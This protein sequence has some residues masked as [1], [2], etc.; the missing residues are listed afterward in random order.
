MRVSLLI[1]FCL[2]VKVS[3]SQSAQS[4]FE[5]GNKAYNA[6]QF[7]KAQSFYEQSISLD[8]ENKFVQ[9][10]F[11]LAN[12]LF[13]QKKYN[14][15]AKQYQS[16]IEKSSDDGWKE[17]GYY[18]LANTFFAKQ[19]YPAAIKTYQQA[20]HLN[21]KDEDARYN[22]ALTIQLS[23]GSSNRISSTSTQKNKMNVPQSRPLTEEEKRQLL[24]H[25]SD[26]ENKTIQELDQN[27]SV[28]RK[29]SVKDW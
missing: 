1:C 9:A 25:L 17:Q 28:G 8:R 15:A 27:K 7:A 14:E 12:A 18:N 19:D 26:M 13:Q 20:L 2:L 29:K 5:D 6:G 3:F 21:P 4:L 23:G 11:N 24:Q 10:N 22:L 16:F